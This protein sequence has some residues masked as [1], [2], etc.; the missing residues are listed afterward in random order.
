[1]A[2]LPPVVDKREQ[3]KRDQAI[4]LLPI[5][6]KL[7]SDLVKRLHAVATESGLDLNTVVT[8]ALSKGLDVQ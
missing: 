5:A 4:G 7:N 6:V 1:L 2:R 8:D 3:R